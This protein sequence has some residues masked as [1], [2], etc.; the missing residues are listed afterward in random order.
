MRAAVSAA[1]LSFVLGCGLWGAG[2]V[3]CA[4]GSMPRGLYVKEPR[5]P[6]QLSVGDIVLACV[7]GPGLVALARDRGYLATGPCAGQSAR[8]IKRVAAVEGDRVRITQT[9]VFVNDRWWPASAPLHVDAK[10]RPMPSAIRLDLRLNGE[11]VLLM[12]DGAPSAF[13]GRYFGITPRKEVH[14]VLR[15]VLSW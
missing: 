11:E 15:P 5:H 7:S 2:V 1:L 4:G 8:V 14:H 6:M 3:Y 9:G 13:D 12:S 10:G